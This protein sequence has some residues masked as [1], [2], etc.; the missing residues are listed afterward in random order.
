MISL[1]KY[2]AGQYCEGG[3]VWPAVDCYGLVLEVRRDMG[4][5]DWPE[6]VSARKGDGSMIRVAGEW[7]PTLARCEPCEGAMAA[8][9]RG[10]ILQHV[11]V[12]V[13]V[14]ADLE[15]LEINP[16]LNVTCLPLSRLK[17]RFLRVEYYQ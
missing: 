2:R 12:V 10:N 15:A 13:A 14:G 11:A 17:R 3:R 4:L 8:C 1:D 7:F 16:G 5:P 6:W 9:Y